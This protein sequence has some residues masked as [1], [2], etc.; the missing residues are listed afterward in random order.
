MLRYFLFMLACAATALAAEGSISGPI[1][2][3]IFDEPTGSVRQI[4][5]V[6]G[7]SYYSPAL[8]SGL[9]R[10]AVSPNGRHAIAVKDGKLVA[11]SLASLQLAV[12]EDAGGE[13]FAWARNS[14]GAAMA[15][16][17]KLMVWSPVTEAVSV[18]GP[19]VDGITAIALDSQGK[20]VYVAVAGDGIYRHRAG[21]SPARL[22]SV[23]LASAIEVTPDGNTLFVLDKAARQVLEID[24]NNGGSTA[25][26]PDATDPAAVS[27]NATGRIVLI[28]DSSQSAF[29]YQRASRT[30]V[31]RM[32]LAVVPTRLSQLADGVFA[33][34][35]RSAAE[36][37]EILTLDPTPASFFVPAP[38]VNQ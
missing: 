25:F 34:N 4:L 22:A 10:A 29:V 17:G 33:L 11:F 5:G 14:S 31:Q 30:L 19:A 3:A 8:I 16:A 9:S 15:A 21:E 36:P 24:A 37:L 2:G 26:G 6:P 23:Q 12:I 20:S 28:A 35:A 38:E 7:A 32:E 13:P 27:V 18:V 1:T